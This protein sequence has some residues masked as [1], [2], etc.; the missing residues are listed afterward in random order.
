[1]RCL[2]LA[3]LAV[4]ALIAA[5]VPALAEGFS[6]GDRPS[7]IV[8][9][10]I[11]SG[12]VISTEDF[13]GKWLLIDFFATW[14]GPCMHELPNLVKETADLRGDNFEVLAVSVDFPNTVDKLKPTLKEHGAK[15]PCIYQGGGW[16]TAP[17]QEWG[18][19]GIPAVFLL[20]PQG[21]IVA[22]GLRGEALRPALEYFLNHGEGVPPIGLSAELS[23]A[24]DGQPVK[25]M[26]NALNPLR[27]PL[28]LR[29]EA[30]QIKPVFAAD[31][32]EHA[33]DP[34]DWQEIQANSEGPEYTLT[35]DC[36]N[37]GFGEGSVELPLDPDSYYLSLEY[38][39]Q[40][41]NSITA[42]NADGIWLGGDEFTQLPAL[43]ARREKE[44][45]AEAGGKSE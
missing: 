22:T 1:M 8:G 10:E 43:K 28:E 39:M 29:I 5:S 11:W 13:R 2:R 33:G 31:D 17:V 32:P 41:P 14:C 21:V 38:Q 24:Q 23:E 44:Q 37:W 18:V 42:D 19:N 35:L 45:A 4:A 26:I 20:N 15:Y 6:V 12:K 16:K 27:T 30:V 40:M 3:V 25:L 7:P 34:V 9:N 36:S